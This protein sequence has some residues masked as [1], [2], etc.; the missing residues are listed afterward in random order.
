MTD[1]PYYVAPPGWDHESENPFTTDGSYSQDWSCYRIVN[2]GADYMPNRRSVRGL[3]YILANRT[4]E[5]LDVRIAD[6]L[7]Y[8]NNHG[9]KVIISC[10]EDMDVDGF[11]QNALQHFPESSIIRP[12][13]PKWL[14]HSTTLDAWENIRSDGEL[15]S[16][17]YLI[18]N[19]VAVKGIG[20]TEFGEPEDYADYVMLAPIEGI[21]P[22]NVVASRHRGHVFTQE[23]VSYEPGARLYFDCHKIINDGLLVRDGIHFFKISERLPLSSYFLASVTTADVDPEGKVLEWTPRSF[24][25]AANYHFMQYISRFAPHQP[26]VTHI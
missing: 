6:F 17:D 20:F 26:R 2:S 15:R 8:E 1:I 9:R 4:V 18:R 12:N 25:D 23:D 11:V 24:L 5:N 16:L 21:G 22:E 14:V 13:D 10:P 3:Y 19:R 7:R